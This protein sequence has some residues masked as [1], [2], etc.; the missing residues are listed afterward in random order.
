V[1]LQGLTPNTVYHYRVIAQN[2][3]GEGGESVVGRDETFTTQG[4]G[5]FLLPDDR[6]WELVSPA[7]DDGTRIEPI[8][9]QWV[10]E[11]AA[12]GDALTY[13]AQS[14]SESEPPGYAEFDQVLAMRGAGG[15][16]AHDLGSPH[17]TETGFVSVGLDEDEF[18]SEDLSSNVVQP[19]GA[20]TPCTSAEGVEQPCFSQDA[21]E[22]TPF[23]HTNFASGEPQAPCTGS[24]Y[25]PLVTADAPFADVPEGTAFGEEGKCPIQEQCGPA[26]EDATPDASHVLLRSHIPLTE[27]TPI[28]RHGG[29]YEWSANKPP[30]EALQLISVLP[31]NG[32]GE[33]LPYSGEGKLYIGGAGGS[34]GA[35]ADDGG[36]VVW[37][38]EGHVYLR[39]NA[40][41]PQSPIS[42]G[43]CATPADA[44]T[45]EIGEGQFA[46]AGAEASKVFF[47]PQAG[48][49][50]F[51]EY[52]V[53]DRQTQ[54]LAPPNAEL[55]GEV[56]GASENGSWVYFVANG[57]FEN[58]GV[59][60]PG[61]VHGTCTG[62]YAPSQLCNLY[63][64]HDGET[65]LVAVL[66]EADESDWA[67]ELRDLTARVSPNGEWLA[68]MSQ[69]SLTG[70]DNADAASG[71][72]DEEVYEY[73]AATRSLSCASCN[74]TGARPNGVEYGQMGNGEGISLAGGHTVFSLS[75]WLAANIPGWTP[76]SGK[77]ISDGTVGA[78]YQSRYLSNEGRLFFNSHDALVPDD[79]NDQ[80]DVYEF[81]PAGYTNAE[82]EVQCTEGASSGSEVFKPARTYEAD[83]GSGE[84]SA[85]CVG[86]ISS[87]TSSEESAFLDA[88]E[89]GADVFV[90]TGSHL[91]GQ[92]VEGGLAVYDAHECAA[93][94][95]CFPPEV[96]VPHV[97]ES[98][99]ACRSAPAPQ[100]EIFGVPASS[101]FSGPGDASPPPALVKTVTKKSVKC[102]KGFDNNGRG[103]CVPKKKG[104]KKRGKKSNHRRGSH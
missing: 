99:D 29:L 88:S 20:F 19:F 1:H 73:D 76:D 45:V 17:A 12:D 64:S 55:R 23:L 78:V 26:F 52:D 6:E 4:A 58:H 49:A 95:P 66:S 87:G 34:R 80:E 57:V 89:S 97:C 51:A 72:P 13:A 3:R 25:R 100:P 22:Q 92:A 7:H 83:G 61:A 2:A 63:V 31:P 81:E 41:Q 102:H 39:E 15:W 35:I 96:V 28:A 21:S 71:E 11:A 30:S 48:L 104:N 9:E 53:E 27:T 5:K 16:S 36:R 46:I 47:L 65:R 10:I 38:A 69:R 62:Y 44:C 74:P 59:P 103:K 79:V 32:K 56:L 91:S 98:A 37:E 84:E 75:S 14:P 60:V 67:Q 40:T 94:S 82:G 101:T 43:K 77:G 86:L 90:L 42:E 93:A 70:Y 85:G 33:A 54:V 8:G 18:F 68:F 24:C 50:G